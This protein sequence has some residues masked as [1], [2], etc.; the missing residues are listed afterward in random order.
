MGSSCFVDRLDVF[1]FKMTSKSKQFFTYLCF[2]SDTLLCIKRHD[3][4]R[5]L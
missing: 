1:I 5:K 3:S 4:N 2:S